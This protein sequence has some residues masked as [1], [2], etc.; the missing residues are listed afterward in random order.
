MFDILKSIVWIVGILVVAYFVMG[1]FG[2]TVNL[3]YFK[4]A[5][6]DCKERIAECS[7]NLLRKGLD[8]A[9][10]DFICVNRDQIIIKK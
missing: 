1:Y 3:D 6:S 10:C 8:N 2:Y 9:K 5:K 7:N 4:D